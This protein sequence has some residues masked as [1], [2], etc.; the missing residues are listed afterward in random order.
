MRARVAALTIGS[1][2]RFSS[3]L[4]PDRVRSVQGLMQIAAAGIG[5][6]SS[7]SADEGGERQAAP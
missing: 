4:A 3:R 1:A 2:S 6:P 7:R 5:S